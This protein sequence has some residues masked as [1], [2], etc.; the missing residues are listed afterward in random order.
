EYSG[1]GPLS[2]S[3][4]PWRGLADACRQT[5]SG[6]RWDYAR[7]SIWPLRREPFADHVL[8]LRG[9]AT[10]RDAAACSR[11]QSSL[12]AQVSR[13]LL[14]SGA[15]TVGLLLV[16]LAVSA[17]ATRTADRAILDASQQFVSPPLDFIS[18]LLS[19]IGGI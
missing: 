18:S 7:G 10:R 6:G 19:A 14:V 13:S 17:R 16:R 2:L 9:P 4:M 12:R 5:R 3:G 15:G 11:T 1:G 8:S